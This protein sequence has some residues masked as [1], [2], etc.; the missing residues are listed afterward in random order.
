MMCSVCLFTHMCSHKMGQYNV[1]RSR[2]PAAWKSPYQRC[3]S[4]ESLDEKVMVD[5]FKEL[6]IIQHTGDAEQPEDVQLKVPDGKNTSLLHHINTL[7][8]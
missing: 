6:E 8:L 3:N 2:G 4:Q 5:Y 1:Q 7:L